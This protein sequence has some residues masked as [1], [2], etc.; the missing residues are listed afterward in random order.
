MNFRY[1]VSLC[2]IVCTSASFAQIPFEVMVGHNQVQHEFFFFKDLDKNQKWNLFSIGS[3][4][5]DYDNED[6]NFSQISS[7]ITYNFTKNWGVSSGAFSF[8]ESIAP[9]V[10][11]SYTYISKNE[12]LYLNLFPTV[13]IE[14]ELNYELFGLLFYTPKI[15]D[16]LHFFGQFVTRTILDNR[17]S[18]HVS[19]SHQLRVGLGLKDLFQ[20]GIGFNLDLQGAD[21]DT[22]NN[23]GLFIRKE[24]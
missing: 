13:I 14:D 19:S 22:T 2:I 7:Q 17:L 12:D 6:K 9:I 16:S 8:N 24:L 20:F 1:I 23:L 4:V 5:L 10:A 18:N 3:F 11:L 21:F 15:N